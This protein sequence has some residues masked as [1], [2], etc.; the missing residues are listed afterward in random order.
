VRCTEDPRL[1]AYLRDRRVPLTVCPLSN[2]KLR[3]FSDMS[4]HNLVQLMDAGLCVTI[5]SD[6]PAYFGG[7]MSDNF[8]A[9]EAAFDL[10]PER[11]RQL[12]RN[13]AEAAFVTEERRRDLVHAI[14]EAE[15]IEAQR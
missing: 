15:L 2:V 12:C 5:N 7:Y 8:R 6:D 13:A 4:Q 3:V 1:V 11:L 10:G 14:D 9:V